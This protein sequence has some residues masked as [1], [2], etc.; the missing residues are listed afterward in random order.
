MQL[1]LRKHG[2]LSSVFFLAF[3]VRLIA[4]D[5][6]LW[7]DEGTTTRVVNEYSFRGIITNFSIHDF[8]PP[9]FYFFMKVWTSLLGLS[10]IALRMPSVL[11]SLLTG[12][13]VYLIGKKVKDKK[14]GMWA[15]AFFLFNPLII[16]YSQEAR[17]YMMV[18][19]LL[20]AALYYFIPLVQS[21]PSYRAVILLNIIIFLSFA[22][23]YGSVFLISGFYLYLLFRKKY[24]LFFFTLPGFLLSLLIL[25][26]LLYRQFLNSQQILQLVQN[27]LLVLGK[28]NI[29]NL[30]LIPMKFSIG[31]IQYLPKSFYYLS[32]GL[33]SLAVFSIVGKGIF[34]QRV[35]AFLF[36]VPLIIGFIFSFA[37]PML[38]YFRFLY[39]VP[40]MSLLLAFGA[41][42]TKTRVLL[43]AGF[44]ACSLVY[45]LNSQY[46]REN[47]KD[48]SRA[49]P[50]KQ[51]VYMIPY[52]ADT[53]T[54]YR[55]DIAVADIRGVSS[56][57]TAKEIYVIPYVVELYGVNYQDS[58]K[59]QGF[60]V[61]AIQTDRSVTVEK[62]LK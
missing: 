43:G 49:I 52:S 56:K 3:L 53:L 19:F 21:A 34:K 44:I 36:L 24:K 50:P 30:L 12:W 60:K 33:W 18:T 61:T 4:L 57:I 45:L 29:K 26:P 6:S 17:M 16:Y 62:W 20:T 9:F 14:T 40:I 25:S 5:Q 31:R 2:I 13:F 27:W 8:H 41:S 42:N 48:I 10:E 59:Q 58:L 23:F 51:T 22:T 11:F 15:A 55:P 35:F 54:Y 37:V 46:H 38:Q 32:A 47:W 39:L 28:A 7:L 1:F